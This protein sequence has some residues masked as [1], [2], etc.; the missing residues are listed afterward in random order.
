MKFIVL[1]FFG[2]NLFAHS[3]SLPLEFTGLDY[4]GL[5]Q[6][7]VEIGKN[8]GLVVVFLSARC[9]CSNSHIEELKKLEKDF[10]DFIFVGIH[11]NM[12]ESQEEALKYFSKLKLPFAVFQ[13][14]DAK[15]ADNFA[16]FKTPHSFVLNGKGEILYQGGVSDSHE[17][18]K[19]QKLFLRNALEDISKGEK[20]QNIEGR[21]LGCFIV[22]K[23]NN[24]I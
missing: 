23:K 14:K 11:S 1:I 12:D 21:T 22:R 18:K 4:S 16:A 15:Y 19:S 8:K 9:P 5:N 13:D 20:V 2:I 24:V 10:S 6:N 3:S 17:L 7:K